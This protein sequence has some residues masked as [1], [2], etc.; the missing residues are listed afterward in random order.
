M[1]GDEG[2]APLVE[3]VAMEVEVRGPWWPR[4]TRP[5]VT[6]PHRVPRRTSILLLLRT[7]LVAMAL[8]VDL[9]VSMAVKGRTTWEGGKG[10]EMWRGGHG[11]QRRSET[12]R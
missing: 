2:R 10:G 12:T 9:V 8:A 4:T 7:R 11:C 1:Y 6:E 3:D 5:R